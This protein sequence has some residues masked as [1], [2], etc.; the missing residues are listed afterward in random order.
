MSHS[1]NRNRL[2]DLENKLMVARGKDEGIVG[3]LGI[4]MYAWLYLG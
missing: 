1:Q 4:D 3:E 2:P